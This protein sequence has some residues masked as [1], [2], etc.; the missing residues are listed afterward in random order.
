MEPEHRLWL[1]ILVSGALVGA[2]MVI[3]GCGMYCVARVARHMLGTSQ[4]AKQT[5][6]TGQVFAIFVALAFATHLLDI[7]LWALTFEAMGLLSPA[8]Y[9]FHF[10]A[11]TYTTLGAPTSLPEQ[12]LLLEAGCAIAGT[13]TFAWTT[14]IMFQ[15]LSRIFQWHSN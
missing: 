9:A 10:A 15:I 3:H 4:H 8:R 2:T 14:A 7:L 12:W 13:F 11:L 1:E 5:A 6:Y